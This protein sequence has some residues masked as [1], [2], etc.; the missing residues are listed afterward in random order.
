MPGWDAWAQPFVLRMALE[1]LPE[2]KFR[3]L[4][5]RVV[6][7]LTFNTLGAARQFIEAHFLFRKSRG[8]PLTAPLTN[9][10]IRSADSAF[11]VPNL[12]LLRLVVL[13]KDAKSCSAT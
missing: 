6:P 5:V 12:A 3:P 1:R 11:L 13:Y 8:L 10:E 9:A 7:S 4:Y 2:A